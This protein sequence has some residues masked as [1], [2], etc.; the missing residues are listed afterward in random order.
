MGLIVLEMIKQQS[1]SAYDLQKSIEKRK[2][3]YWV[4]MSIPSIY[5]K[6]LKLTEKRY[7]KTRLIKEICSQR[8]F[9]K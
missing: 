1:Q 2:I 5:K 7:L 4:K 3:C 8:Q 9:M 6:V